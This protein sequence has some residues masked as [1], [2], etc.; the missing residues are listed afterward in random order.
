MAKSRKMS[1]R[2]KFISGVIETILRLLP[3]GVAR[4]THNS[5]ALGTA[6]VTFSPVEKH[7]KANDWNP[8]A[9]S[10]LSW[11]MLA[12]SDGVTPKRIRNYALWRDGRGHYIIDF[13]LSFM[14]SRVCGRPFSP[15]SG[16]TVF[17][18]ADGNVVV[19]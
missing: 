9:N 10:A 19:Q 5:N 1:P 13:E 2:D 18:D 16:V 6:F 12:A 14:P 15:Q 11:V 4:V 17:L 7:R 8:H 3:K